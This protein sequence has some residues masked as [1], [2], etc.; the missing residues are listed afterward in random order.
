L[1]RELKR[2]IKEDEFVSTME[3]VV[4]WASARRDEVRIAAGLL[5]VLGAAAVAFFYFHGQRAREA[6]NALQE[7]LDVWRAPVEAELPPTADKPTGQVF[8]T[9]DEKYKSA[10][11]AFEGVERRYPSRPEAESARYY[12]ALCRERLKQYDEAEKGLKALA[13]RKA[14]ARL[15]PTVARIALAD[16]YRQRGQVD[17]A[18]DSYRAV[19]ADR[20]FPFPRDYALMSLA[21]TLEE[22]NRLAEARAS[23]K[24]LAE[25]FPASVYA[26]EA[27]RRAERLQAAS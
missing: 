24:R 27:K 23:Y 25:D 8:A 4:T 6:E 14:G 15:E 3:R 7:A 21:S 20:D 19:V 1:D 2:Q 12:A 22:A 5:V 13:D 16:L 18:V 26:P 10:A 11:A 17:K 9:A